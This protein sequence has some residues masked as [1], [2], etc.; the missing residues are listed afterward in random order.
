VYDPGME[1]AG[2][3]AGSF[4]HPRACEAIRTPTAAK[5]M[6]YVAKNRPFVIRGIGKKWKA[7]K[8]WNKQYLLDRIGDTMVG[9]EV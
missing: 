7:Y 9:V 5:F 2:A 3:A 4:A 8:L 1:K 6:E